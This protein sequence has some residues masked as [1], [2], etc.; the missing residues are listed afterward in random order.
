MNEI[1]FQNQRRQE[2]SIRTCIG[3]F[4]LAVL[5]LG[6]L[7]PQIAFAQEDRIA[8]LEQRLKTL[9]DEVERLKEEL[10]VVKERKAEGVALGEKAPGDKVRFHGYGELH[11]KNTSQEGQNNRMDFHRM[12][13]GFE[14]P[15]ADRIVFDAEIDFEHAGSEIELE[16]A[17]LDFLLSD[18]FNLRM[19]SLLMPVGYLNEYHEPVKFYSAE[20]PYVQRDIIPTTWQEGGI[21][22]FGAPIPELNYR[23]YLVNGLDANQFVASSGIRGGRD[24][25]TNSKSD[26]LALVARLEYNPT[27]NLDLGLSGYLGDAAQNNSSLGDARVS[28]LETDVR[29]RWKRFELTGLLTKIDV[30]DTERINAVTGQV[31]GEEIFGWYLE[32]AYHLGGLFMPE[33]QDLVLFTRHEQYDT[34]FEVASSLVSDSANER[35]VTTLGLAYY[36]IPQVVLKADLENWEDGTGADWR[37]FNLG[38]GFEY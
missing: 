38:L 32:G 20:R 19:G 35:K 9:M 36:P 3:R 5:V 34:Q 37:Q 1:E 28:I 22:I 17:K 21:G 33:G 4:I 10:Q 31:I 27:L 7:D 13:L 16:Y 18:A 24:K 11:Y 25:V 12:V 26:D 30:D 29:L 6:S 2:M 23:L 15:F 14:I 8:V